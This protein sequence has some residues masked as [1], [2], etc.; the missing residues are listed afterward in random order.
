MGLHNFAHCLR[1]EIL[2]APGAQIFER[3]WH[4]VVIGKFL[5]GSM[6]ILCH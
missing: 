5:L 1:T 2:T 6:I 3:K 4:E